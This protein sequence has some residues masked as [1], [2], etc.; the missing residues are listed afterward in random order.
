MP[1]Y[2]FVY[3][4]G[5]DKNAEQVYFSL[6]KD[7]LFWKD[8]NRG[9]PVLCSDIG[10]KGV[11][12]PFLVRDPENHKYYLMATD[13]RIAADKGWEKAQ[14]DGSKDIIVWESENLT[15]WSEP[16]KCQL[17]FEGAGCVWAPEAV[18]DAEKKEFFVFFAS[19]VKLPGDL[20]PKQRIY[21]TY[22]PDF[23]SF[24]KPTVYIERNCHVIDTTLVHT[25]GV[26]YRFSKDETCG[27]IIL[28]K[29]KSLDG[30]FVRIRSAGLDQLEGVEGPEC[31][32]LPDGHTWCLIVDRF[33]EKKGYLPV[34]ADD[35][36]KGKFHALEEGQ[37]DMGE[38]KKRHGCVLK[39]S[40]EEYTRIWNTFGDGNPILEGLYAD[41][42]LAYFD[43]R[44]YLYPT[45][46]GYPG[47]SGSSFSVFSSDDGRHFRNEGKILDLATEQVPWSVGYAWAPC[48]LRRENKYYFYF[49]G[50]NKNDISCIGVAASDKP[51]GPFS[52]RP[53]PMITMEMV[54]RHG[55]DMDQVIDPSVYAEGDDVYILFG[56]GK[57]VIAKLTKD[58]IGIDE[59]TLTV[60]EGAYDFREA[61]SVFRRGGIYHFTWSCCDTGSEDYHVNYGI[62]E[63]LYGPIQF[64]KTILKKGKLNLGTGHHSILKLPGKD[65]YKIAYHRFATPLKKYPDGKGYHR[66]ICVTDIEFDASGKIKEIELP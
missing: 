44:Y 13:L 54:E 3:F 42:D 59:D 46:D 34:L 57:P 41:P 43:G 30:E 63:S 45:T 29:G 58:R 16:W 36:E 20:K 8:L 23:H 18:Y 52:A 12:D 4:T 33:K 51:T 48:I 26:Y 50:K 66:E 27:R 40:D 1:G 39:I 31:Y 62:S 14:Y 5:E 2:L 19:M 32:L 17:G 25:G 61:V 55:I 56:N 7:G 6:S 21:G 60:L 35:L 10:E 24:S 15:L 65:E 53:E 28:E 22:T 49:C 9:N 11:R 38:N 37:Y 64:E 47:W